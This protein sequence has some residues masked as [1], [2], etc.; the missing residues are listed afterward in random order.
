M[1]TVGPTRSTS[2][3]GLSDHHS[4]AHPFGSTM[5]WARTSTFFNSIESNPG[6]LRVIIPS[7]CGKQGFPSAQ[8]YLSPLFCTVNTLCAPST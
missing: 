6:Y 3:S 2:S 7:R 5:I 4:T 8:P 1:T